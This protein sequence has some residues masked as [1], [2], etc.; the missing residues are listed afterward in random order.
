M[1][2]VIKYN[3]EGSL[4]RHDQLELFEM[5]KFVAK[6]CEK[7]NIP[8]W[9]SSGTLLGAAR[10]KGFI[11]WDDDMDIVLLKKDYKKLEKILCELDSE[12]YV[13]HCKKTDIEYVNMFGKFRKKNGRVSSP[14]KRYLYYKWEGIGFDVF[15]IEKMNYFSAFWSSFLYNRI[16]NKTENVRNHY[17]RHFCIK[18]I[19]FIFDI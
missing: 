15:A 8:W 1:S 7:N 19:E 10:H 2:N 13:F 18:S 4:L 16:Q 5:V 11:P 17:I 3:P 12:E 9:L 14:S 6:I